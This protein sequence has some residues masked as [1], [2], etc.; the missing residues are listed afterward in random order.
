MEDVSTKIDV[1]GEART[2]NGIEGV[3]DLAWSHR[4]SDG[5]QY[6]VATSSGKN[7]K[8]MVWKVT[9]EGATIMKFGPNGTELG[10]DVEH[11]M[12]LSD[13][14]NSQFAPREVSAD[15]IMLDYLRLECADFSPPV[16][17]VTTS[18]STTYMNR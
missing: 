1:L 4:R 13:D 11:L 9:D 15:K 5:A 10:L 7:P 16:R 6:L 2:F 12:V 14:A 18:K 3:N 17:A 8:L